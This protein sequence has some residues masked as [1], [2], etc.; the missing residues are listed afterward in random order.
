MPPKKPRGNAAKATPVTRPKRTAPIAKSPAGRGIQQAASTGVRKGARVR[1]TSPRGKASEGGDD[2]TQPISKPTVSKPKRGR[3]PKGRSDVSHPTVP[4]HDPRLLK[5]INSNRTPIAKLTPSHPPPSNPRAAAAAKTPGATEPKKRGRPPKTPVVA[6]TPATTPKRG[7][8]RP[9]KSIDA[10]NAAAAT[11]AGK[12]RG[13]PPKALV[14]QSSG[15]PRGRPPKTPTRAATTPGK[16]RGRPPGKNAVTPKAKAVTPRAAAAA[17][18]LGADSSPEVEERVERPRANKRAKTVPATPASP[19]GGLFTRPPVGRRVSLAGEAVDVHTDLDSLEREGRMDAVVKVF[20]TH[21]EPNY[22]LPWQRKRQVASTSS[23]FIIPGRR[24][25]TNAHSVEHHTQVKLKKRG[26]DVKY[27]ARVLA[28]GVECDLALLTVE[29]DEFFEG[30]A[31]VQFGPLP[32]LSAPVS[33]IG[34]P[35]GGVA[36]SITSGVVSRTEVTNYA[37]GG[38]DLLGVQIDAAINSGNSGGPAFNAKGECVG[39][40]FQSLKHDDAEN[41]GYVIPPPVVKHF[42]HDYD[43]NKRYTG[44]PSLPFSWQRVE[45]PAMRKWLKMKTGQKGVLISAVEPLMKDKIAL[46]KNDVLVSIDGTEIASDGT[47]PFRAGEPITFNYLVS[48][49]YVGESAIVK[50]LRDG[51]MN[52]TSITFNAMKRLVP[53]H[54]EGTPPSYFIAGGLV[55]TTVCVPFLK[56]EYGK[57]Y[58]FDAPVKLLEKFCHGRVEEDGQQVVICAQVLAAEVNRGYEDLHN[59]IVKSFDGVKIANLAQLAQAV[60]SSKVEFMRFELDHD[61]S[62]VM[63]TKAAN[64]ATKAILKTH[65]IPSAKSADLR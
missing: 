15:K 13:R 3:P 24:V 34:Y 9:P 45:S 19:R 40:A 49:K 55:F 12:K 21:T 1:V 23:G 25:L 33:V 35:I 53:W 38:I 32:H 57:D 11:S 42:I 26:S 27:V 6:K 8:G 43:K 22:S 62:V 5:S 29:E 54:I 39:V 18:L 44:F 41:I 51:K 64:A 61:I 65:A 10:P 52:E 7:P 37:H 63:D 56:N 36:I 28:I 59:T 48:E 17:I 31:P 14:P 47:V 58:D 2:D 4:M 50:Y 60:E 30:V 20:C 46:R 16:K